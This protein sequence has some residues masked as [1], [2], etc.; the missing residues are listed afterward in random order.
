MP[1]DELAWSTTLEDWVPIGSAHVHMALAVT[2]E[3]L[4]W[5][6]GR[7]FFSGYP[8]LSTSSVGPSG[9]GSAVPKRVT[10]KTMSAR[11]PAGATA[12]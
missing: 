9:R 12:A 4:L 5:I 6:N 2:D 7:G 3:E 10:W 11:A 1:G 8:H